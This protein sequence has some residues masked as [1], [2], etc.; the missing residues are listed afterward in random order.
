MVLRSLSRSSTLELSVRGV[1]CTAP[2]YLWL[3]IFTAQ[4]HKEERFM[5]PAYPF[6]CLSAAFSLH[7]IL[8]YLGSS[9][10]KQAV[11]RIPAK[12][13]L[14]AVTALVLLAM[15]GGLLRTVGMITAYNAPLKVFEPLRSPDIANTS[16][17]VC[18]GKEWYRFP[19]SYFVPQNMRTKFVKSEFNG[20]LPGEFPES[21]TLQGRLEGASRIPT[22][23]NDL[24]QEDP[25]KYVSVSISL[26]RFP[27]PDQSIAKLSIQIIRSIF[28]NAP[29]SSIPTSQAKPQQ[30]SNLTT[31]ST[32]SD[33]RNCPVTSSS[34]PRAQV[35]WDA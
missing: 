21:A 19:S 16:G 5:Y 7:M 17:S 27:E 24:N 18:L 14:A 10:P 30:S 11:G 2:F 20:L 25:E 31:S 34:T 28:L 15:N 8:G 6:L 13:K 26:I 33:G 12:L 1:Q 4:P 29:S 23:M 9:D 35:S 22:G 3:A 32:K